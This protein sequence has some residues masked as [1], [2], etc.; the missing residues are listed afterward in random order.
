MPDSVT[1]IL[2]A[3][4]QGATEFLPIS[5]S[6]H[7]ILV[8]SL[9]GWSDQGLS[10]DIAVHVG[11][12]AASIYYFRA[13]IAEMAA[14]WLK[15]I[16]GKG[17]SDAANTAWHLIVASIPVAVAGALAHDLVETRLRSMVVIAVTTLAFG[18]WLWYADFKKR[19]ARQIV[20]LRMTDAIWIGLAQAIAIVPG[21]SRSGV[22][23]TACLML[24]MSRHAA[25]R[26]AFLL[27]IPAITMAGAWQLG[28]FLLDGGE[29]EIAK[30]ALAAS[31]S[32][33]T[34]WLVIHGLLK[35][36]ER[37]GLLPFVLYRIG[38]A[39]ALFMIALAA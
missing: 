18:L 23:I 4:I 26:F 28:N 11:T 36:I 9:F 25:A 1:N 3:L 12:L 37:I 10:F 17:A 13:D 38:L 7:L 16:A 33:V 8:P 32:A 31:V 27:A 22:V 34:A 20:S 15:S 19:G 24:G 2:L 14:D 35:F 39:A 21:T 6:A 5:S 29:F 30:F